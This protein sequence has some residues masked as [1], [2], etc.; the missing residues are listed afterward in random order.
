MKLLNNEIPKKMEKKAD[1]KAKKIFKKYGDDRKKDIHY[2]IE[3]NQFLKSEFGLK[4]FKFNADDKNKGTVDPKAIAIGTI[5][6]G[7][8][9]YR[10]SMAFMSWI[11]AYGYTPYL[12]DLFDAENSATA[13][14]IKDLE[15]KYAKFSRLSANSKLFNKYVW[16]KATYTGFRNLKFAVNQYKMTEMFSGVYKNI[17]NKIPFIATHGYAAQSASFH[18]DNVYQAI[19]D[20]FALGLYLANGIKSYTQTTSLY[21]NY[22]MLNNFDKNKVLN[23]MDESDIEYVGHFIDKELVDNIEVDHK[24][25]MKRFDSK[26][27]RRFLFTIGGS[28]AQ[29]EYLAKFIPTILEDVKKGKTSLWINVGNHMKAYEILKEKVPGL[30][31]LA[32]EHFDYEEQKDFAKNA[33]DGKVEGLHIFYNEQTEPAV[34]I[35]NLLMRASDIMATKPSE[36]AFYPVPKMHIQHVGKHEVHGGLHAEEIG[37]SVFEAEEPS[38]VLEVYDALMN[39]NI[40]KVLSEQIV[41]NKKAEKYDGAKKIVEEI[42]QNMKKKGVK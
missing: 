19:P 30:K 4:Q 23:R 18:F 28:G 10:I 25:R 22:L 13:N 8:G 41:L 35:T 38:K 9:H 16:E 29:S 24:R 3:D 7:F 39:T 42:I 27:S 21:M 32:I 2:S 14:T 11:K 26:E 31:E 40:L 36:L 12:I 15:H 20:N 33:L 5:K 6:M 17:D 34:F 1:N 37:D